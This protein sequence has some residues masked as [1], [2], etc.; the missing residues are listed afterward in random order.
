MKVTLRTFLFTNNQILLNLL[1]FQNENSLKNELLA[2]QYLTRKYGA[3]MESTI[4]PILF[5]FIKIISFK[6]HRFP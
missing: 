2:N 3:D 5:L 4:I 6:V 1:I